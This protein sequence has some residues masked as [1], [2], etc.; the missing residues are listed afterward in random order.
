VKHFLEPFRKRS[1]KHDFLFGCHVEV[2]RDLH[3]SIKYCKKEGDFTERGTAP[4]SKKEQGDTESER[5]RSI[6][7][8]CEEDRLEDLDEKTRTR[9]YRM[10]EYHRAKGAKRRKMLDTDAQHLWYYGDSGTGK[11]RKA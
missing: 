4:I 8:A 10:V 7:L 3:A 5:W 9:D 2:C 11:S 6:R 1:A